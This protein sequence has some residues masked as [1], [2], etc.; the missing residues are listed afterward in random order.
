[1]ALR[2]SVFLRTWTYRIADD[3]RQ[4]P[5]W[6]RG[7]HFSAAAAAVAQY[8]PGSEISNWS[9]C[10]CK[11]N[12]LPTQVF[13]D[14]WTSST[15]LFRFSSCLPPPPHPPTPTPPHPSVYLLG[16]VHSAC[17]IGPSNPSR[18]TVGTG[19]LSIRYSS[20]KLHAQTRKNIKPV[21]HTCTR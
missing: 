16:L 9:S 4:H 11:Q 2:I 17:N 18:R 7:S 19:T 1:M 13:F 20:L 12:D 3:T 5:T 8:F 14:H 15:F 21:H 6:E 10:I